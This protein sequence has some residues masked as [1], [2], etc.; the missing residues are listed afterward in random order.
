MAGW[1]ETLS[2][3]SAPHSRPLD[4]SG[5]RSR[6]KGLRLL[7]DRRSGRWGFS[8]STQLLQSGPQL[9]TFSRAGQ[10]VQLSCPTGTTFQRPPWL[11]WERGPVGI[12]WPGKSHIMKKGPRWSLCHWTEDKILGS[13]E[14]ATKGREC[15]RTFVIL[16]F[17]YWLW[18]FFIYSGY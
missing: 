18:K 4:A 2:T 1:Q 5:V 9:I 6:G 8:L 14:K 13:S 16:T 11:C 15:C 17:S 7:R 12:E 3:F 10:G